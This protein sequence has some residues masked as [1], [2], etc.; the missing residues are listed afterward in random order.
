MI[1]A[2]AASS[3]EAQG[4]SLRRDVVSSRTSVTTPLS[5]LRASRSRYRLG[6]LAFARSRHSAE[7]G[8]ALLQTGMA[9]VMPRKAPGLS[10]RSDERERLV[11][12]LAG[13]LVTCL[14]HF[15]A[16]LNDPPAIDVRRIRAICLLRIKRRALS[17]LHQI[18]TL[19]SGYGSKLWRFVAPKQQSPTLRKCRGALV[20]ARARSVGKASVCVDPSRSTP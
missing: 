10:A 12:V 2:V 6:R 19:H 18:I 17:S 7:M 15:R 3:A 4:R 13:R 14:S 20:R 16:G 9:K 8:S 1:N 11:W 5:P